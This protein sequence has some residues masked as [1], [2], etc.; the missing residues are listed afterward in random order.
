MNILEKQLHTQHCDSGITHE[1]V[2]RKTGAAVAD[3]RSKTCSN[4]NFVKLSRPFQDK[5]D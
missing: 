3:T 5:F 2:I 1:K 4:A